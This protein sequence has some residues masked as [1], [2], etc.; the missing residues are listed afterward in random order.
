MDKLVKT[1]LDELRMQM[2][3]AQVLFGFQFHGTF[4]DAFG[5]ISNT[6][7]MVH[8][9]ALGLILVTF[10]ILVSVPSQH[11]I[12]ERGQDTS[13][14]LRL[15]SAYAAVALLPFAIAIG[16]DVFVVSERQL[17][18]PGAGITAGLLTAIALSAFYGFGRIIG[19]SEA[20][21]MQKESETPLHAKIDQLLTEARVILPGAQALLGFQFAVML[22]K[23]FG[24]LPADVRAVHFAGLL[25]DALSIILLLAPAALHRIAFRGRDVARFHKIGSIIV[26]IALAPLAAGVT[27]DLYV[28]TFKIFG[29]LTFALSTA[30]AALGLL[31][32]LWYLLP[33]AV[34]IAR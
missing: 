29:N 13:R 10:A 23:A 26:T 15:A 34:R 25:A 1:A 27:A 22:T 11:R 5:D 17:G 7:R 33:L 8:V 14:I 6:A 3:G 9:L 20:P 30:V 24:E 28:A 18:A 31:I 19:K 21:P 32:G 2:L 12:V 16:A 4:Q